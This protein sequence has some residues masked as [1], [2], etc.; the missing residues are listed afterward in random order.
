MEMTERNLLRMV[1]KEIIETRVELRDAIRQLSKRMNKHM[2]KIDDDLDALV[3]A[4]EAED[5]KIDSLIELVK[6][7]TQP[8]GLNEEQQAKLD[9][10]LTAI[11]DNPDRIQAAIDAHTTA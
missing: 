1:L 3:A 11:K 10:A 6:T 9:K 5:T 7:M 2:A 4:A 8:L